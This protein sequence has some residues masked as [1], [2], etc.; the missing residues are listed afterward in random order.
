MAVDYLQLRRRLHSF[1]DFTNKTVLFVGAGGRQLFDPVIQTK[2]LIAIDS[3]TE[4]L[5]HLKSNIAAQGAEDSKLVVASRFEDVTLGGDTVYFEFCLH[6]M[7][8][9]HE[10]LTHA[11]RLAPDI[12]VFD[13]APDSP[14]SFCAGEEQ[15][16]Q[17]STQALRDFG[18]RRQE[19][20]A[21][22]QRFRDYDELHAKMSGQGAV[23]AERILQFAGVTDIVIPMTCQLS[24]L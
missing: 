1:Y 24:L 15:Q 23:A 12:V 11:R 14:W 20:L 18:I 16:I 13:H 8:N 10:A 22:E 3:N 2:K 9:P 17:R 4:A 5:M 7:T 6:E 19:T 21:I